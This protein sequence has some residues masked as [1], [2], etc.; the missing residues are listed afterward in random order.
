MPFSDGVWWDEKEKI[1]K[2]WYYGQHTGTGYAVSRDGVNWEKPDLTGEPG[3]GNR[4]LRQLR[5]STSLWLDHDEKDPAR[6]Y[7]LW[8]CANSRSKAIDGNNLEFQLFFSPDGI[9]WNGPVWKSGVLRDRSTVY[10]NPFR[11]VWAYSIKMRPTAPVVGEDRPM[12]PGVRSR[13]YREARDVLAPWDD[14]EVVPWLG[15]DRLDLPRNDGIDRQTIAGQHIYNLDAVAYES[16]MLGMPSI[17]HGNGTGP[18][19]RGHMNHTGVAFSRDGFHW[20]RTNREPFLPM[21]KIPLTGTVPTCSRRAAA[22]WS[23][24]TRSTFITA[25]GAIRTKPPALA[26]RRYGAM[27]S[28]RWLRM[29]RAAR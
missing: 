12:M 22:A 19:Q 27:G 8:V 16:L 4:V 5:D 17:F 6:R 10:W 9:R 20:D 13:A 26:W 2:L 1:F 21:G 29:R 24:A 3:A 11:R 23:L 25:P 15:A 18:R 28:P 7:K 14:A